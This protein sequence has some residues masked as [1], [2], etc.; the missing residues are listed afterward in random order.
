M[1]SAPSPELRPRPL[2]AV[3][4]AVVLALAIAV[5]VVSFAPRS[6][7]AGSVVITRN[8]EE[9]GRWALGMDGKAIVEVDGRYPLRVCIDYDIVY[10]E[11]ADCPT[12]DCVRTGM[13][14]RPGQSIICLPNQVVIK[15]VGNDSSGPDIVIG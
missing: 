4:A 2:D 5:A 3:V 13:I 7:D 10:V 8:G 14:H 1:N 9:L 11:H 12:Q 15:I 6:S